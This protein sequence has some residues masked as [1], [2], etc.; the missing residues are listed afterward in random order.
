MYEIIKNSKS[1]LLFIAL[2]FIATIPFGCE[3]EKQNPNFQADAANPEFMHR[4]MQ[5]LSEVIKYDLFAP[6]IASRIYTYSHIAAYQA[7]NA[8]TADYQT[9]VG[10]INGL[11][12]LPSVEKDKIY[13]LPLSAVCAYLKVGR[14]LI[15]SEDSL[16]N[17]RKTILS[18]FKKIGIPREIYE[19]SV[20]FGDTIGGNIIAWSSKDNYA[21]TRSKSKYAVTPSNAT[22]WRP[23]SPDYGD[24]LE[25]HWCELRTLVMDSAAQIKPIPAV[26]YDTLKSSAFYKMA[27]ETYNLVKT[28]APDKT[29]TAWYWDDNPAATFNTG[30]VNVTRKKISPAGHWLWITMYN[31]R[32]NKK[33]IYQSIDSYL[34]VALA[35]FDGFIACWD[36]KYRS[37][38]IRP[39]SY[40]A[41]YI[42][43]NWL[44]II[45][46]PPFPEYTSGHSVIS[47]ASSQI[48]THLFGENVAFTDS[49]EVQFGLAARHYNSF[50]E[51]GEQAAMSRIYAGIH[52]RPACAEGFKQGVA[53][54]NLIIQKI[55]TKKN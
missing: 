36:E 28:N 1:I 11:Q 29:E 15:F 51:A 23:T 50:K 46:T 55:K 6:M 9:L 42:D 13:C 2:S 5:A 53:V 31:A 40:I 52:Y 12:N 26:K 35:Q 22:R 14:K 32:Q 18:D 17:F 21:Q 41:K 27:L 39:E 47:G 24:A 37:E 43:P 44:P 4:S 20:A 30:H 48:L 3:T 33:D 34:R 19:R 49:T 25:P 54:G 38:V 45:I 8:Q 16:D 10:Q 7:A